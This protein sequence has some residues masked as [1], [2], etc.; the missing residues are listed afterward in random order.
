MKTDILK[1]C[2][3]CTT[4]VAEEWASPLRIVM[5]RYE[6]NTKPRMAAFLA[7]IGHETAG[8]TC[9]EED[10]GHNAATLLKQFPQHFNAGNV[11]KFSGNAE[12]IANRI[13]A[14]YCGNGIESSGDGWRYRR[15]GILPIWG[16]NNYHLCGQALGL[17][18]LAN[19]E[20]L[21]EPYAAAL[22]AG[23]IWDE[24]NLNFYAEN[25]EFDKM[26]MVI[27]GSMID[28]ELR[29]SRHQKALIFLADVKIP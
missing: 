13:Y 10:A 21:A 23:W 22:A 15:R 25:G 28:R 8:L 12:A 2:L 29:R 11:R 24:K 5:Q 14:G 26:A 27:T 7:Q 18:L 19:P 6:I 20:T 1:K 9:L 4:Q 3:N 16:R 17:D